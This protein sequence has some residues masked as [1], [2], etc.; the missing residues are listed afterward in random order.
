MMDL[1]PRASVDTMCCH[2]SAIDEKAALNPGGSP[3]SRVIEILENGNSGI[4]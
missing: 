3:F 2:Q 1:P 4:E